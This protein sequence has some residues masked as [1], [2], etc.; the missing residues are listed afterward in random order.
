MIGISI[1]LL[2]SSKLCLG[3]GDFVDKEEFDE[4]KRMV[5]I[6]KNTVDKGE[7][8]KYDD[9]DRKYKQLEGKYHDV[10]FELD[11]I[12]FQ[13]QSTGQEIPEASNIVE[14]S[15]DFQEDNTRQ[16]RHFHRNSTD[17]K[18]RN[19]IITDLFSQRTR[20]KTKGPKQR[21]ISNFPRRDSG[22]RF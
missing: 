22:K 17:R 16:K 2:L 7:K 20:P 21:S 15:K 13:L 4:L 12:K 14:K 18:T 10:L 5:N 3:D 9:L 6:L 19:E 1:F 8:R 11:E